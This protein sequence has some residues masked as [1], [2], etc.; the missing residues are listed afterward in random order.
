MGELTDFNDLHL[1]GG[2]DVVKEQIMSVVK[3]DSPAPLVCESADFT[4]D[5]LLESFA[6]IYGETKIFDL[7]NKKV[8]KKTAFFDLVTRELGNEWMKH[9]NR[10]T[11]PL[12]DVKSLLSKGGKGEQDELLERFVFVY[13]TKNIW[14]K[15]IKELVPADVLKLSIP[16]DYQWWLENPRR[17]EIHVNNLVFD[18]KLK[19]NPK[20]HINLFQGLPLR[21][22]DNISGCQH[23]I[24]L[25]KHLCNHNEAV[26]DWVCKWFAYPLQHVGAK[27]DSAILI[28]SDVQGSGK[29]M[30]FADLVCKIYGDYASVLGQHQLESQYTEWRSKLLYA[31][32]E[33]IFSRNQKYSHTGTLKH[34]I[35]GKTQR[36]EKKF[37]SGWEEANHM[38]GCFLS[39]EH[40]PF[41]IETTD[42]RMMVVWPRRTMPKELQMAVGREI[43]KGGAEALYRFFLDYPLGGFDEHTKPLLTDAKK[44]LISYGLPSW[45]TF[46]E[47]WES[48]F[49]DLPYC[50]CLTSDLYTAYSR[51]C[52][53]R[54]ENIISHTKFS[55]ILSNKFQKKIGRY[56][57]P[58]TTIKLRANVFIVNP[59]ITDQTEVE[60][61]TDSIRSFKSKLDD[62]EHE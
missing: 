58:G 62:M 36:I 44:R 21:P 10:K 32:F 53:L 30:F 33:E 23:S 28:H 27:M 20:T 40:Q 7:T 42:R 61:L 17:K 48:G 16:T 60:W 2:L 39:N 1:A 56:Y 35:T 3:S 59:P 46:I 52:R 57:K 15:K 26:F 11:I 29:S 14:D 6:L 43:D 51:Y 8:L 54:N 19:F 37:V 49:L 45:D 47:H 55:T 50:S 9:E 24:E 41:P 38:N 25:L 4:I 22:A 12:A 34:M 5:K 18:P 31:A 13:P